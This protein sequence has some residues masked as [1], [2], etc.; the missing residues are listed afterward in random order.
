MAGKDGMARHRLSRR[1]FM[2]LTGAALVA[3]QASHRAPLLSWSGHAWKV[4]PASWGGLP[5]PNRWAASN[6]TVQDGILRLAINRARRGW[7]CA[8][9][10]SR[11]SFGYGRYEFVVNSNLARL[12]PWVV[13][14]LFTYA[15]DGVPSHNEIDIEVAKWGH[16]RD[17]TNAQFVQ[18]PHREPGN[19]KRITL[20]HHPPYT[21]WWE[22][23]PGRIV[24]GATDAA[25]ELLSAR[26]RPTL[27]T[28]AT[29]LVHLNLWLAEGHRP[30][31]PTAIEIA[32]F[33][34]TAP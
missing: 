16:R 28:P 33:A 30:A 19:T 24:W 18:Q 3:S 25:G 21:L 34:H 4:R 7:T 10:Q 27:F 22:W 23:T 1:G 15:E 17:P 2:K 32:G 20:S 26:S 8:E 31:R 13:L 9:I 29:E 6:V 12:D 14:G 11:R 5:G